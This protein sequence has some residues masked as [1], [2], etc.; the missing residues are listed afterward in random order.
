MLFDPRGLSTRK[1][2]AA[3]AF[4]NGL[5]VVANRTAWTDDVFEHGRNVCLFDGTVPGL[6]R[7]VRTLEADPALADRIAAGGQ[8]LYRDR[9]SAEAVAERIVRI[10]SD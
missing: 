10:L 8:A 4:L 9:L 3:T 6:I 1:G 2:S 5:P 7:A